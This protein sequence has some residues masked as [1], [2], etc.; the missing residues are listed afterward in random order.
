MKR[1]VVNS[2][3]VRNILLLVAFMIVIIDVNAQKA[4]MYIGVSYRNSGNGLG[5]AINPQIGLRKKAHE[6]ILGTNIQKRNHNLTGVNLRYNYNLG[7]VNKTEF[8]LFY[9]VNYFNN[10][11]LGKNYVEVETHCKP[12]YA[13]FY[14]GYKMKVVGEHGG[15]GIRICQSNYFNGFVLIGAGCYQTLSPYPK[16]LFRLREKSGMSLLLNIGFNVKLS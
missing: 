16:E 14:Q 2:N 4:Q 6:I 12:E 9:D 5:S 11:F 7:K 1:S 15:F 13:S 3:S 10:A 8:F